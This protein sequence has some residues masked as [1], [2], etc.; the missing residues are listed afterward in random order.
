MT[1][2]EMLIHTIKAALTLFDVISGHQVLPSKARRHLVAALTAL[3]G[4]EQK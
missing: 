2:K 3:E 1:P 4:G